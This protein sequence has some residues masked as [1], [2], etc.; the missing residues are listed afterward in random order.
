[1]FLD[2]NILYGFSKLFEYYV[3]CWGPIRPREFQLHNVAHG[4]KAKTHCQ[5]KMS[6]NI[7]KFKKDRSSML[8]VDIEDPPIHFDIWCHYSS[9]LSPLL[10][11]GPLQSCCNL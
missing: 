4:D 8:N 9:S 7:I 6:H 1:M 2:T 10:L 5:N 3:I 11:A